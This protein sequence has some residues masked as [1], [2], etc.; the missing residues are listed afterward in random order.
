MLGLNIEQ[1]V[2]ADCYS[3]LFITQYPHHACLTSQHRFRNSDTFIVLFFGASFSVQV[4]ICFQ[5]CVTFR[6][7]DP[8]AAVVA[9]DGKRATCG[10][11]VCLEFFG[12]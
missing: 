2:I 5:T 10:G 7:Q 6:V 4:E 8:K 12:V 11:A 9:P 1:I 3:R